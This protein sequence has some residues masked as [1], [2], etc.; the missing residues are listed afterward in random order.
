MAE[1]PPEQQAETALTF[2]EFLES[3]PP[4]HRADVVGLWEFETRGVSSFH[5]LSTPELFLHCPSEACNGLRYFR[6]T[7]GN[8]HFSKPELSTFL[9]YQC[10][11]C[12][13]TEKMYALHATMAPRTSAALQSGRVAKFG[14]LPAFGPPTPPRLLR[15]FGEERENFLK[16]RRCESQGLGIGAFSYYRRVVENQKDK[17]FD[18]IIRVSE[19]IGAPPEMLDALK[20]AKSENQFSKALNSAREAIPQAL[21]INGHNPLTLLHS[22]L[23]DGLHERSDDECLEVAQDVRLVM[24]ELAERLGQALKDDAA[25]N[26]AV[27]RLMNARNPKP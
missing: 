11:N 17:I 23:S 3:T 8:T 15:L 19:K 4:A 6:Y 14:E 27:A 2:S 20:T 16:G 22:A 5:M 24:S 26:T 7:E 13:K 18:E 12:A 25:L 1:Q 10:S 9:T 21:L